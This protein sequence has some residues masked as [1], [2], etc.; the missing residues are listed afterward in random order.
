MIKIKMSTTD[1]TMDP[2]YVVPGRFWPEI[3]DAVHAKYDVVTWLD[4]L[5]DRLDLDL[6]RLRHEL[7]P[8]QRYRF[9]A[10][11][12]LIISHRDTDYYVAPQTVGFFLWNLYKIYTHL[13]IPTEHTIILTNQA[14]VVQEASVLAQ[15]F[16]VNSF[17]VRY[18]PYVWFPPPRD[19]CAVDLAAHQVHHAYAMINGRP[20]QHR[21][22]AL[23][24]MQE[25]NMLD[26]G[27]V[28]LR[29]SVGHVQFDTGTLP[30]VDTEAVPDGL[31]LRTT[32]PPTRI[33]DDLILTEAQRQ[34]YHRRVA[35]VNCER[36]HPDVTGDA[37]DISSRFQN[38]FLQKALW[39]IVTETVGEY[40]HSFFTEKTAKAILS[41]RPFVILG[42]SNTISTL[43]DLGFRSFA[44]WIDECYDHGAT[45]ADRIDHALLQLLPFAAQTPEQLRTVLSD[46]AAVLEHNFQHYLEQFGHK[47]LHY[48]IESVL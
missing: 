44:A 47:D 32:T 14:G 30:V 1:T 19:V 24:R 46:M 33:N 7:L 18:C 17:Q 25:L 8:F 38:D 28:T 10:R 12:R 45:V 15:A 11:Q 27:M 39:N 23:C 9:D 21:L 6:A 48:F 16:N 4:I 20:R 35:E 34:L 22:Y 26:H 43:Q 2:G 42:G 5:D 41:K 40:P 3:V 37:L 36:R 31:H 13:D 29:P